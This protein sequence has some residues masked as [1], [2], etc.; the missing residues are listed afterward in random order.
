[1][2]KYKNA[3]ILRDRED[4][5][6]IVNAYADEDSDNMMRDVSK[7]ILGRR[8]MKEVQEVFE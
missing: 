3:Y 5:E 4:G 2:N 8:Y 1:M 6:I 7:V